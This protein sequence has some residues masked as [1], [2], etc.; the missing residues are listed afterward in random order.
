MTRSSICFIQLTAH[1]ILGRNTTSYSSGSALLFHGEV[2]AVFDIIGLD[3]FH[4]DRSVTIGM[5]ASKWF[6]PRVR[7]TAGPQADCV[8]HKLSW[9]SEFAERP[10][11]QGQDT[12]CKNAYY[13]KD[14]VIH[15]IL[16]GSVTHNIRSR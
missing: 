14:N 6:G 16:F 2:E 9:F 8:F 5:F 15:E 4:T 7:K 11:K 10:A 13:D 1:R 3:I 12:D